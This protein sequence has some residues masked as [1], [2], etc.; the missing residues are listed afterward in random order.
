MVS[1]FDGEIGTLITRKL[2]DIMEPLDGERVRTGLFRID[3]QTW[4]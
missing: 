1:I 2:C 4:N 3:V